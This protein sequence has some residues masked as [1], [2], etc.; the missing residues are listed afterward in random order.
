MT[1]AEFIVS[2]KQSLPDVFA[3]KAA[4]EKAYAAFCCIL[5]DAAVTEAGIRLPQVG[6]FSITHRAARTG[7]NPRTG[8][9]IRI[10]ARKA[11]K[12]TPSKALAEKVQKK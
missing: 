7:R 5:A 8:K 2:L 10:P 3:T 4:A 9:A 1:K 6:S 12:F 11:V